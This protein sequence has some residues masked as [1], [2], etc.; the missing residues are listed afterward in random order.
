MTKMPGLTAD[1]IRAARDYL[2]EPL[3]VPKWGGTVYLRSLSL[4]DA[5]VFQNVSA[6]AAAGT[7]TTDDMVKVVAVCLCDENGTRL[8]DDNT[9]AD[10]AA[11][12]LDVIRQLFDKAV[13]VIGLSKQGVEDEK[14]E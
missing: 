11:K 9:V 13:V 8:F 2:I 7:F 14:K 5:R 4:Q 12:D 3:D 10:L 1:Q 6:A